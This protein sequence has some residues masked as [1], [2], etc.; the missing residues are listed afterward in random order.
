VRIALTLSGFGNYASPGNSIT[1]APVPFQINVSLLDLPYGSIRGQSFLFDTGAQVTIISTR[2]A[3][4]LGLDLQH[5]QFTTLLEGVGGSQ[6][7]GGY[8]IPEL[9]LPATDGGSVRFI[10]VPVF[11][12][13]LAQGLD[14]VLG[15]NL[16]DTA[17]TML[18]DPFG[19]GGASV[20]FTFSKAAR[21]SAGAQTDVVSKLDQLGVPFAGAIDGSQVP[22]LDFNTGTISGQVFLDYNANGLAD[23]NEPGL[24]GQTVFLDLNNSG[25]LDPGDP[26]ATTDQNGFYQFTGLAAGTYTVRESVSGDYATLGPTGA[27]A[28]VVIGAN[29]AVDHVKFANLAVEPDAAT[30]FVAELYGALLD[31]APD[32]AGLSTW[33]QELDQGMSRDQVA[34]AVWDSPEHRGLEVDT[35]YQTFLHRDADAAGRL[36]WMNAF[37]SGL[38]EVQVEQGFLMSPEY[39]A[40]HA[41]DRA[42]LTG[43]YTDLL[44]RQPDGAESLLW[45]SALQSGISRAQV[46]M[47]FLTSDEYYLRNLS[48][49]YTDF[50]HR[51]ADAAG[52]QNWLTLL[53]DGSV[54]L[55]Q[56]GQ[57]LLGS[58]EFFA[59]ASRLS[60]S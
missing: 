46:A 12:A 11:V 51:D 40:A 52:Q 33:V 9:D 57:S 14:G 48:H 54:S 59:W 49:Y 60:T 20:S 4:A 31:R 43:L 7:I 37:L 45:Q 39:Q 8:T 6:R 38:S 1:E 41:D 55:E 10:N 25:R 30:A 53:H 29:S 32:A 34:Q 16:F 5:P 3:Q 35:F 26:T 36:N 13:D 24:A 23:K 2:D 42:F 22:G 27:A 28:T 21:V 15:M 50:L 19:A 56:A 17:T 44:G 58:E 18:Y 47:A